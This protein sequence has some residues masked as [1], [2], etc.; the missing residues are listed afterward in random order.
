MYVRYDNADAN[1][2]VDYLA[3]T[4]QIF[5]DYY[6]EADIPK[7]IEYQLKYEKLVSNNSQDRTDKIA[8]ILIDMYSFDEK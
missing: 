7:L 5:R 4:R 6:N 8:K 3:V 2:K 1:H